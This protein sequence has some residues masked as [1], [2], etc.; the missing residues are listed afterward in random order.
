MP[1][2][3][4]TIW[5]ECVLII[6]GPKMASY[7]LSGMGAASS[8]YNEMQ[9]LKAS[10]ESAFKALSSAPHQFESKAKFTEL[11][12]CRR[13]LG[14]NVRLSRL[15]LDTS[16][17]LALIVTLGGEGSLMKMIGRSLSMAS[18][19]LLSLRDRLKGN[20]ISGADKDVRSIDVDI[21]DSG[22]ALNIGDQEKCLQTLLGCFKFAVVSAKNSSAEAAFAGHYFGVM[23]HL[24]RSI[25]NVRKVFSAYMANDVLDCCLESLAR[26]G[27]G[28]EAINNHLLAVIRETFFG[29]SSI[30]EMFRVSVQIVNSKEALI[31]DGGSNNPYRKL[32]ICIHYFCHSGTQGSQAGAKGGIWEGFL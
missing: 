25:G 14:E 7:Q 26:P 16:I 6:D 17:Y 28:N 20:A 4:L 15:P 23:K 30:D 31:V 2:S 10:S 24:Q 12:R 8:C 13:V 32:F 18:E 11:V 27:E 1:L 22:N 29:N 3:S 5:S 9:G 21:E 19:C